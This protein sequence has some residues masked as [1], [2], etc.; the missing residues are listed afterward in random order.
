MKDKNSSWQHILQKN[1]FFPF[2]IILFVLCV[3]L[4][5]RYFFVSTKGSEQ[6]LKIFQVARH[7]FRLLVIERGI[8]K[9]ARIIPIKSQISGN[10]GKLIWVI[11][12]GQQVNK[13]LLVARFDT[14]PLMDTLQN[15][16]QHLIDAKAQLE[17][18][19]KA[20]E[21]LK[22]AEKSKEE[23]MQRKLE[24]AGIK[25]NDLKNG[26]GPL[27]RRQLEQEVK[28]ARRN[29]EIET[30]DLEDLK[31]LLDK[32]YVILREYEKERNSRYKRH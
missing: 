2:G 23:A 8:V 26:S 25:A 6:K 30:R 13:G 9:P 14:K 15:A 7:S 5:S 19:L 24:I 10:Q 32:G 3:L 22:E 16:E 12:E 28:K 21:L 27:K 4:V 31:P 29:Y 1:V 17:V 20:L 18:S 11:D